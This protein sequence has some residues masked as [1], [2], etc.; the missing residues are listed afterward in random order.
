MEAVRLTWHLVVTGKHE[1][2]AQRILQRVQ[3]AIGRTI[4]VQAIERYHKDPGQFSIRFTTP[5]DEAAPAD[6]VF[7]ALTDAQRLGSGWTVIGPMICQNN[8]WTF[9]MVAA[10]NANGRFLVPGVVWTH[11][12]VRPADQPADEAPPEP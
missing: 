1:R 12:E 9:E 5:L 6:A 3:A 2:S 10:A 4:E 8:R 7:Q 11:I